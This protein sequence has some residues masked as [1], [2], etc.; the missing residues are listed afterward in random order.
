MLPLWIE[1]LRNR[2]DD[3]KRDAGAREP[4]ERESAR[5][6]FYNNFKQQQHNNKRKTMNETRSVSPTS[7]RP[8]QAPIH[9][10]STMVRIHSLL[11]VSISSPEATEPKRNTNIPKIAHTSFVPS[12]LYNNAASNTL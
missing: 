11:Y 9:Y 3:V 4:S 8:N 1:R 10:S 6:S 5:I 2:R 7:K 12:V